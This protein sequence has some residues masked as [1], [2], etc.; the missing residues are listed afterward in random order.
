MVK[1]PNLMQGSHKVNHTDIATLGSTDV[2]VTRMGVGTN[3][4]GGLHEAIAE[5][6]AIDTIDRCW[7]V[8][9][10]YFDSAPVY[11]YGNAERAVGAALG[12]KPRDQFTLETKVGRLLLED[13]PPEREDTMVLWKGEQLY[14]GTR[15]VRPYFDFSYDGVMKSIEDSRIRMG[16][17]RFDI[18]HI[19]DPDLYPDEAIEG[20]FRALSELKSQSVIGAIGCGMNQW[21]MLSEFVD[22]ADFDCFLLAGRYSLLDHSALSKLLPLCDRRDISL[23]IG[24]V[25]NSGIL[26][27]PDPGSIGTVSDDPTSFSKWK[28]NVTFNYVPAERDIV[29]QAGRLK[30]VCDRHAVPL[31]AA[32]IQFPLHHPAVKSVLIG[33]RSTHHVDSNV[34]MM[35]VDIPDDLW[36][37]LKHEGLIPTSAPTS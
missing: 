35:N 34:E 37:E 24:G 2:T 10:R 16:I 31:M 7:D 5:Q 12:G 15:G 28:E 36:S 21:E 23:I 4:L 25:Y 3:P 6:D 22:R 1:P 26:A 9:I 30:A 17:D 19:H 14:R 11:G 27:H 32:A 13:G 8:G 18:L 20:A 33:P 29:A